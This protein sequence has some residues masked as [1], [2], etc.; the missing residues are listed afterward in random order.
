MP[1]VSFV[2]SGALQKS[3][4]REA[5][6]RLILDSIRRKPGISRAEIAR[7]T[8]LPRTSVT[9][10]VDRLLRRRLVKEQTVENGAQAG[11]PPAALRL[12]GDSKLAI[13]VEISRPVSRIILADLN[14]EILRSRTVAWQPDATSFLNQIAA[15][16]RVVSNSYQSRRILG[17]GVS[18]PGTIDK[19]TGRVL[20][21]EALDWVG[22][23]VGELLRSRIDLPIWFEND[24]NLSALAEQWYAPAQGES[25]R[26]YVYVRMQG[27]LGTGVVVDGRVL[28]G[29]ASAGVEFGH[30]M[31]DP[32]GRP[33]ACGNRGCWEQYASDGALVRAYDPSG[34]EDSFSIVRLA[35]AGD[36][37]ALDALRTTAYYLALGFVNMIAALNPQA[38]IMGEP[39]ASAWDLVEDVVQSELRERLPVYSLNGLR[40]LPSRIGADSALRG[41]AALVLAHF[42]TRF[43]HTRGDALP[44]GVSIQSYG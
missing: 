17:V 44:N 37:R 39:F 1:T 36:G 2:T 21:A 24:A 5:N 35:R 15:G 13:G 20:G 18:L 41:A 4:L 22:V 33:C 26:Y 16:I 19:S 9:F 6:E 25:L 23:E 10:V 40:L 31:L 27:G 34:R 14:G 42:L 38:I 29:V 12:R 8:G 28:H 7:I 43:D 32:N 11:R 3:A 30:V